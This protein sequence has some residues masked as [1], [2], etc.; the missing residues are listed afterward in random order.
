MPVTTTPDHD[1][2]APPADGKRSRGTK[3][4]IGLLVAIGLFWIAIYG[5]TLLSGPHRPPGR[6][7]DPAFATAAEPI[8]TATAD[9]IAD[10]G[11]PTAVSSPLERA[12]MVDAENE[13]LRSMVADLGDL[14][15]PSGEQGGWVTEWLGD[16]GTHI[17]DRQAWADDLE[18][19]D[20]PPFTETARNGEQISKGID[21]FAEANEMPSC[22]TAGD[23]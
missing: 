6:L 21:Y 15:R 1:D 10:L 17:A 18:A 16:W 11:L 8:C 7:T 3:V 5:Y 14:D 9:A 22:A 13:L 23:V 20:D 4:Q 19:G 12:R 2:E